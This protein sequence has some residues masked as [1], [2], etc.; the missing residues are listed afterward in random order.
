MLTINLNKNRLLDAEDEKPRYSPWGAIQTI[1]TICPGIWS[2]TTASH[3]GIIL[4]AAHQ[5]LMPDYMRA[6]NF[7]GAD[8]RCYEEDCSWCLPVL[9]FRSEFREWQKADLI[10]RAEEWA[11]L[12]QTGYLKELPTDIV[13]QAENH[14][15]LWYRE[16]FAKY[17]EEQGDAWIFELLD[18]GVDY[19]DISRLITERYSVCT[20]DAQGILDAI[21]ERQNPNS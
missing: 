8:S 17:Q 6:R 18:A 20:S 12:L 11:K 3:G 19:G 4:D 1:K 16:V 21:I 13:T 14:C 5:A 15:R 7:L 2:V 9:V 10:E